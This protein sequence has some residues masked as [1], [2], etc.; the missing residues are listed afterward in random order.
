KHVFLSALSQSHVVNVVCYFGVCLAITGAVYGVLQWA[1]QVTPLAAVPLA[2][3]V[4]Y[5]TINFHHY[6]VDGVIWKVRKK[7]IQENLRIAS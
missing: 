2:A 1:L 6:I 5:Q 7:K 4:V 3:V